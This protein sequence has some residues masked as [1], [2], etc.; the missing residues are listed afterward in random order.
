MRMVERDKNHPSIILW[1]LGNESAVGAAHY[2]MY[3][4]SKS[5]DPSRPVQYEGG[6]G[7]SAVTDVICPMYARVPTISSWARGWDRRPVIL[8]EYQHAMGNSNGN[9]K[10]YW[11]AFRAEKGLQGG[12]I[13]D[14]VDQAMKEAKY[15]QQPIGIRLESADPKTLELRNRFS[16]LILATP[17][18][19]TSAFAPDGTLPTVS[20]VLHLK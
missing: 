4:W 1:S 2:A 9:L 17:G 15:L 13:W 19:A 14:W 6:Q 11:D 18:G 5:R 8:C 3:K 20:L 7:R 16:F 10:E 12:F